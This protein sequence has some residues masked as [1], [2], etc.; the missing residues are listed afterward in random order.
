[1][2]LDIKA[3]MNMAEIRGHSCGSIVLMV[4]QLNSSKFVSSILTDESGE[5]LVGTDCG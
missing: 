4:Q 2:C 3:F 1:M 5:E